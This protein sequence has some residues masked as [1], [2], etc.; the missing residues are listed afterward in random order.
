MNAATCAVSRSSCR[1][2]PMKRALLI[3]I[4]LLLPAEARAGD[5]S[6]ADTQAD[7]FA[8]SPDKSASEPDED[9]LLRGPTRPTPPAAPTPPPAAGR[10]PA[11]PASR[12]ARRTVPP[13]DDGRS[14]P[15]T[16]A[17]E[18]PGAVALELST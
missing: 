10:T 11:R 4:V 9:A 5:P 16:T 15:A 3:A 18:E 6:G 14:S 12:S 13:S 2:T 7:P 8:P 17:T 1:R